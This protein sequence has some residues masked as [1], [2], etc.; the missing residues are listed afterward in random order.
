MTPLQL[1][2][3]V[4]RDTLEAEAEKLAQNS[5]LRT[6]AR[7]AWKRVK[8]GELQGTILA[9]RL[10]RLFFLIESFDSSPAATGAVKSGDPQPR[11]TQVAGVELLEPARVERNHMT[12]EELL[13]LSYEQRAELPIS[14]CDFCADCTGCDLCPGC[15][16]CTDCADCTDCDFC[17][18]CDYSTDCDFCNGCTDCTRCINCTECIGIRNG[19]NLQ[20]VAW[21]V[22]L[23]AAQWERLACPAGSS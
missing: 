13:S 23:T 4:F 2:V 12:P 15:N 1:V 5:T 21:G 6:N 20:Y 16:G 22:Q 10:S 17:T 11:T 14:E 7:D 18:D 19:K 3:D 9:S 8:Q